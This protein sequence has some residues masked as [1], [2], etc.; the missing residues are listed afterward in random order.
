MLVYF[1]EPYRDEL[2][3]SLLARYHRHVGSSSPKQTLDDLFGSR[4]VIARLDLQGSLGLLSTHLPPGWGM[5]PERLAV[6]YTLFP[7]Y[8]AF[9]P[10]GV[11]KRVLRALIGGSLAGLH[12]LL[13]LASAASR[14]RQ[15]RFCPECVLEMERTHGEPYWRRTHQ[16]PGAL[17]CPDHGVILRSSGIPSALG[18]RHAFIAATSANCDCGRNVTPTSLE[19]DET[20]L[21]VARACRQALEIMPQARNREKWAAWYRIGL[22]RAGLSSSSGRVKQNELEAR[23][24][25]HF[26]VALQPLLA[27]VGLADMSWLVAL[28]QRPSRALHPLLNILLQEFL[29]GLASDEPFGAGPWPCLNPL[30]GHQ[31]ELLVER[32]VTHRNRGRIVGVFEC[33]CGYAYA[34]N[35]D[36]SS[37]TLSRPR[38]LRFG[39]E[40]DR[41]IRQLVDDRIGIRQ[42]A[43]RL[44]VDPRTVR[45]RAAKLNL[46]AIWAPANVSIPV[47]CDS[48]GYRKA[49]LDLQQ[50]HP[51]LGRKALSELEPALFMWLYRHDKE[52][53]VTN[54]PAAK[55][56]RRVRVVSP[57]ASLDLEWMQRVT[58]L[59]EKIRQ[60]L[61][62]RKVTLAEICRR[63]AD[64]TWLS[65]HLRRLPNTAVLLGRLRDTTASFQ[66]RRVAWAAHELARAGQS[67]AVWRI[68][69]KAGLSRQVTMEVEAALELAVSTVV[70]LS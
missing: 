46:N 3:Y 40:F 10:A 67:L 6:D 44:H 19:N 54:Q 28:T 7:Y 68:R 65:S 2:L 15:L 21:S 17:L 53:L 32:V 14:V 58:D 38:P 11:R 18:N 5:G 51:N 39:A 45:L 24:R 25:D 36:H 62:P 42:A 59:A 31:G 30:S 33:A 26:G 20:L 66:R 29:K 43:R 22:I 60:E 61:P 63:T 37:G 41:L 35:V 55:V 34:R 69:R 9:Q 49:W 57:W 56:S 64:P 52:W 50:N 16:L 8:L 70:P 48:G 27:D 12:L 13:G 1:P 4:G 23:F 47:V